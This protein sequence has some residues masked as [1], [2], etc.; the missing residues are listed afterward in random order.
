MNP[1][2]WVFWKLVVQS[3]KVVNIHVDH[4]CM[5]FAR[6]AMILLAC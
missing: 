1:I 6:K 4:D 2:E 5:S 3:I